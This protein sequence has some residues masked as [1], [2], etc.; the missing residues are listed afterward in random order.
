MNV[1]PGVFG[2][3][4]PPVSW[5]PV[6]EVM[7]MRQSGDDEGFPS[8]FP[9]PARGPKPIRM[10]HPEEGEPRGE[11]WAFL[12]AVALLVGVTVAIGYLIG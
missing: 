6:L 11:T 9:D 8:G 1:Q 3:V 2:R 12:R 7:V 10:G 4:W 5:T